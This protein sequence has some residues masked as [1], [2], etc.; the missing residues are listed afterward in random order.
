MTIY[1]LARELRVSS[2]TVSRALRDDPLVTERT[3]KRI[4]EFAEKKG[5]RANFYARTLR[6]HRANSI[7]LLVNDLQNHFTGSV[8]AGAEA[9]LAAAGYNLV[10]ANSRDS[11]E[12]ELNHVRNF[13]D[14]WVDGLIISPSPETERLDHFLPLLDKGMPVVLLNRIQQD[15]SFPTVAFDNHDCGRVATQHLLAEGCRR[16]LHVTGPLSRGDYN[17]RC[18]GYRDAMH[19]AG[20]PVDGQSLIV[21][22]LGAESA[23]AAA[24]KI[25]RMR[26]LPDG[27]FVS[28]DYAAALCMRTLKEH[29][30]RV[31]QDIAVV[32][33]NNDR[34]GI[35]ME[36]ALTTMS[37]P[38]WRLG[39]LAAKDLINR[40]ASGGAGQPITITMVR[41]EL[42]IRQ[43]SLRSA[44]R[45]G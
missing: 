10:V 32:G 20:L 15:H 30:L 42:V 39:E 40:L 7:G 14:R 44:M 1:D 45:M 36:P 8:L 22:D 13:L 28:D 24:E 11:H 9:V 2:S 29:K 33:F 38:G 31:P 17:D 6:S 25:A 34:I 3:R 43:S 4:K 27:L 5:Y 19:Q 12:T 21:N 23:R 26:P 18:R 37:F 35:L 41:S 16:I